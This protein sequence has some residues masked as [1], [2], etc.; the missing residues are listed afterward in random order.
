MTEYKEN[1]MY[2]IEKL[3]DWQIEMIVLEFL[4]G[5]N[6]KQLENVEREVSTYERVN[7]ELD[8]IYGKNS[9]GN[10]SL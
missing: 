9:R 8:E 7:K 4:S 5:A 10:V 1:L 2:R 3:D 6:D